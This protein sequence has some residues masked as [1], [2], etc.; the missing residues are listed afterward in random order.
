MTST[1]SPAASTP[2]TGW[3]STCPGTRRRRRSRWTS[4]VPAPSRGLGSSFGSSLRNRTNLNLE[5]FWY[6]VFFNYFIIIDWHDSNK[7]AP[8]TLSVL[9]HHLSASPLCRHSDVKHD[10]RFCQCIILNLYYNWEFKM[11]SSLNSRQR[12]IISLYNQ[13]LHDY[14]K[15]KPNIK[16]MQIMLYSLILPSKW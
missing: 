15:H 5:R 1:W 14:I 6:L 2:S 10:L 16:L 4:S 9:D 3:S 8:C 7:S 11:K 13:H 12:S